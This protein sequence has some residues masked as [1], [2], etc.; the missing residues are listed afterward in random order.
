MEKRAAKGP[1]SPPGPGTRPLPLALGSRKCVPLWSEYGKARLTA[2]SD[3]MLV[4]F[5]TR[6]ESLTTEK[7][8]STL[9]PHGVARS[10]HCTA[11]RDGDPLPPGRRRGRWGALG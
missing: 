1:L 6:F 5:A 8:S 7:K 3:H 2:W 11:K 9:P 4:P 10:R